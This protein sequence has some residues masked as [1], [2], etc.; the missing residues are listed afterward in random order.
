MKRIAF[1]PALILL[2]AVAPVL[3]A[4]GARRFFVALPDEAIALRSI[5]PEAG[6]RAVNET[7]VACPQHGMVEG[8]PLHH[9]RP[10]ILDQN[11]GRRGQA[12]ERCLAVWM[13]EVQS[14]G[15]L[16]RVLREKADPHALRRQ[17][18]IGAEVPGQ[19]TAAHRLDL[20]DL[21]AEVGELVTREGPGQDVR[22]VEHSYA[23]QR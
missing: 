1:V 19:I 17:R 20:D 3:W 14:Q 5:L 4:A 11:V 6:N 15:F 8:E 23:G 21:G 12:F 18:R 16:A 2:L 9:A 22:Q 7:R 10:E 13:L